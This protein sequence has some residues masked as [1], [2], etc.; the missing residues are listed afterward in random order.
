MAVALGLSPRELDAIADSEPLLYDAL[1]AG[2]RERWTTTDELLAGLYELTHAIY[3]V[4]LAQAG[5]KKI[6]E[7]LRVP[8][9]GDETK[10]APKKTKKTTGA[11]LR[12]WVQARKGG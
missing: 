5:V 12:Q 6:P 4:N 10:A 3:R 11:E 1:V 9:P 7:P 2:V 8:R